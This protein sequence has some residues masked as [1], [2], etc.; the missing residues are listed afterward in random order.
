M[1]IPAVL[2]YFD[3]EATMGILAALAYFVDNFAAN[4][5]CGHS[6]C[7]VVIRN[8]QKRVKR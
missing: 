5:R 1:G 4:R 8:G 6:V 2:P 3:S 7:K